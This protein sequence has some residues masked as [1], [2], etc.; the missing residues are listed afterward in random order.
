VNVFA[1]LAR[2]E[3]EVLGMKLHDAEIL[4]CL[5][6]FGFGGFL[7]TFDFGLHFANGA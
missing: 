5:S 6:S 3:G 2:V 4:L 1:M 7:A